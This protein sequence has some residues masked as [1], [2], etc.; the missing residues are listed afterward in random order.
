MHEAA[1]A[2][3]AAGAMLHQ[4]ESRNHPN[5]SGHLLTDEATGV[6]VGGA[7]V[8]VQWTLLT[9]EA[10][11]WP[12]RTFGRTQIHLGSFAGSAEKQ[13]QL[14]G[15]VDL[16]LVFQVSIHPSVRCIQAPSQA[17]HDTEMVATHRSSVAPGTGTRRHTWS[18]TPIIPLSAV[19][20]AAI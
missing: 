11:Q 1:N 5:V 17:S 18:F 7:G 12:I 20:T 13:W 3:G 6:C 4:E 9:F 15:G 16:G 8:Q 19:I 2:S 14:L 10:S